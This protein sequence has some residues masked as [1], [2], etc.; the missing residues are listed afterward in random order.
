MSRMRIDD[1]DIRD[2]DI[3]EILL[4][5]FPDIIH[6]VGEDG[7][8]VY[9]NKKAESLLKYS[10]DELIG[11]DVRK[12]Y[13]DEVI[14]QLEAGF[15][16]LKQK[17]DKTVESLLQAKDGEKIAVEIRSFSIYDDDGNFI[18][19]FSI[20]RDIRE[21]KELQNSLIHASRLAAIG[22]LASG[23]A[24]DINNPLTVI[25]LSNEMMLRSFDTE[26]LQ[27]DDLDRASAYASDIRRASKSI[28]KLADHLRN[29]SRG[30][31]GNH[32]PIDIDACIEDALFI[33]SNKVKSRNV[34]VHFEPAKNTHI[35]MGITNNIEQVFAN[36]ISNACDA[37]EQCDKKE[38]TISIMDESKDNQDFWR[39]DIAD[40]GTGI[41]P[42]DL[43]SIFQ[44]FFTTKAEGK[45]TGL[46]LSITRGIVHDHKGDVTVESEIGCGTTFSVYLLKSE[47]SA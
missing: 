19:T 22:E 31:A 17:G 21:V 11:M 10:R 29:F 42:E 16:N 27:G 23:V 6:S 43:K 30:V 36:L 25:L 41:N 26:V 45:G 5:N 8:I 2:A 7:K 32:V 18:R 38:L 47:P 33:T 14:K 4:D 35:T 20:L 37:M 1:Q 40:T 44:S 28:Q 24:H 34:T 13:A 39:I 9:T 15:T 3:F 12:I 46:G